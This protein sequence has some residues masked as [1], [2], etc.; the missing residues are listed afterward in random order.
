MSHKILIVDDSPLVH[1]IFGTQLEKAGFTVIH[2]EDG[3]EAINSTFVEAPD[4]II[5][6]IKM[7]KINGYQVCRLLK[8]H[9]STRNTPIVLITGE[10][11]VDRV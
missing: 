9:P 7:P 3:M 10:T 6:D 5:L 8:D 4:L 2:A 11:S 1:K